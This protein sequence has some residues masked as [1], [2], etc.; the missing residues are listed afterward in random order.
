MSL[1]KNTSTTKKISIKSHLKTLGIVKLKSKQKEIINLILKKKD[2]IGILPT[3][4]GKSIC[5]ILPYL[6]KKKNVIV[7]SPLI[8]LMKDQYDKLKE[9]G[10]STLVFNSTFN[11]LSSEKRIEILN[12]KKRYIM[13]FSPESFKNNLYMFE[14]LLKSKLISLIA[15]DECHCVC[16][17]KEF[18]SDYTE[19][20]IITKFKKKHNIKVTTL[21][22]TATA[23]HDMRCKIIDIL[24][25][26][27]PILIKESAFKKNISLFVKRKSGISFDV[28]NIY[29]IITKSNGVAKKCIIYCKTKANCEKISKA[30]CNKGLECNHY[31]A[32]I[33][34]YDRAQIQ[35]QFK[36][37]LLDVIVATIAFGMGIDI[38]NIYLIIH[39]GIS[40]NIES[41]YQEI[42]RGG[43]DG[44]EIEC[45][46]FWNE[47]DFI[48][49]TYF[50]KQIENKEF[51]KSEYKKL[52]EIRK[53][54]DNHQCRM[55]FICNY[56]GDNIDNCGKCD[57]CTSKSKQSKFTDFGMVKISSSISVYDVSENKCLKEDIISFR[58][59]L[60]LLFTEIE[61]GLGMTNLVKI[62]MG[63]NKEYKTCTVYG[64]MN[65]YKKEDI[66]NYI[67][68]VNHG[69]YISRKSIVGNE[70]A[71]YYCINRCGENWINNNKD[72]IESSINKIKIVQN[73]YK[74]Y[75]ELKIENKI[76][77]SRKYKKLIEWRSNIAK[78]NKKPAYHILT[79]KIVKSIIINEPKNNKEL[80]Q[81]KGIGPKKL[82]QYGDII[83]KLIS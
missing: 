54:I 19:L 8:S 17:W 23:T 21:A 72:L 69:E 81:I 77:T 32:G 38:P 22:L 56:F 33:D 7:I 16:S 50:I 10:I 47:R 1:S 36:N 51:Q 24:K 45:H 41:Y 13:Y 40:K 35:S 5:Y 59:L 67:R 62:L 2:I 18:R 29:E 73:K 4:Y 46:A 82:Q 27:S 75:L 39:Y 61:K 68:K 48:T 80:L 57:N 83:L 11:S 20:N 44:S 25:L 74:K 79:D 65:H 3:G 52:N 66:K 78:L 43:R 71:K 49:N 60:L 26:Q 76:K 15:I 12:G 9:K 58:Y 55:K 37:G 14:K 30:L 53:Y 64:S 70:M 63:K 6:L 42:G 28:D 34:S 31:H